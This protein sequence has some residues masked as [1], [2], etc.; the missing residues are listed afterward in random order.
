MNIKI[1]RFGIDVGGTKTEGVILDADGRE[2]F[3]ER[4][5][6]DRSSY[7]SVLAGVESVY[8]R[9]CDDARGAPHTLGIGT[10]GAISARTGLLKNSNTTCMNGMPV[11]GDLGTL[12]GRGFALENDANCFAL[13]EAL[14]GAGRG[15]RFVFGVIMGTGCGGG[16]VIDGRV[17]RGLQ[18]I[19]GE[20]GHTSID[21]AGPSCY[22]GSR[23]CV[24]TYISGSGLERRYAELG[25]EPLGVE[26]IVAGARMGDA[27]GTAVMD[28]FFARLG[29]ALANLI[30]VLDPDVVVLG[31]GLSNIDELYSHGVAE[32]ARCVFSDS[33]ETPIVRNEL[34]D[35]A[36]VIGAALVGV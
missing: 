34:G 33:L 35:S 5:A 22:C 12:F 28:E 10:P 31:G 14:H 32:V 18:L 8:R 9:M 16:L 36:G 11:L 21:P 19:A 24:E 7:R 1:L 13:A 27:R 15:K 17:H 23:G 29:R 3:R 25:G 6:T 20:W 26:A 2:L 30:A 4:V